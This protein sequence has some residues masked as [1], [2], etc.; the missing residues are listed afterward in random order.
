MTGIM[1]LTTLAPLFFGF[2]LFRVTSSYFDQ[3]L[4]YFIGFAIQIFIVFSFIAVVLSLPFEDK[5]K[6][7]MEIVKPYDK[8]LEHDGQRVDFNKW[9]SLCLT[10]SLGGPTTKDKCRG[11]VVSPT[12]VAAGGIG[13]FINWVGKEL[14]I[15]AV[16]AY[17]VEV[18]LKAAPNIAATIAISPYSTYMPGFSGGLP[19]IDNMANSAMAGTRAFGSS[20]NALSGSGNAFRAATQSLLTGGR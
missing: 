9:C 14:I 2:A 1:F 13:G 18:I 16:M 6:N 3:W 11:D 8:T 19:I 12:N 10:D 5:F 7:V 4:K 17:L 15:L 20:G